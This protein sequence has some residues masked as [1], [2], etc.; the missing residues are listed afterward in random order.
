MSNPQGKTD[1]LEQWRELRDT[2]M[3][4]WAKASGEAVNSEAYAQATG[5]MLDAFLATSSPYRDAQKK[6]M[7]S[8]LEQCNMPS[9]D[10]YVRLADRL[11][12]LELLL[13]DMDAKLRQVYHLISRVASYEPRPSA[14][15]ITAVPA[16]AAKHAEPEAQAVSEPAF[17][18]ELEAAQEPAIPAAEHAAAP[19]RSPKNGQAAKSKSHGASTKSRKKGV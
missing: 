8:A 14:S 17:A 16:T 2:Y 9:R 5:A 18:P 4:I 10:D 12:N 11:G 7:I 3:D 15:H 6:A 19:Q 1:P 13:D